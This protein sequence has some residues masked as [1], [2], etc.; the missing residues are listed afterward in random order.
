VSA[1]GPGKLAEVR[2]HELMLPCGDGQPRVD[3][4]IAST[5]G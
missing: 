3:N 2:T 5:Y 1:P 4:T